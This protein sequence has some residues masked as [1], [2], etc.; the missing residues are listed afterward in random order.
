MHWPK[1]GATNYYAKLGLSD[2]CHAIRGSVVCNCC[3][4]IDSEP[5]R[6]ET[7]WDI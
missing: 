6:Y 4:V 5:P 7:E 2:P 1:T 3:D